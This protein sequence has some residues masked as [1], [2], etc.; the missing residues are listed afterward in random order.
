M[1]RRLRAES[2]SDFFLNHHRH[3][4]NMVLVCNKTLHQWRCDVVWEVSYHMKHSIRPFYAE[5]IAFDDFDIRGYR[6]AQGNN[7]IAI[8]LDRNDASSRRGQFDRKCSGAW[9]DFYNSVRTID[10]SELDNP[11]QDGTVRKEMLA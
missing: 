2:F 9:S 4:E 3:V 7:Q 11:S 5:G 1:R 10:I 8:N 6:A